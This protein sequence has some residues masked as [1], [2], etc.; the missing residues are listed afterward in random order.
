[1]TSSEW[2]KHAGWWQKGFTDHRIRDAADYG[3]YVE[4]I[5]NNP[6]NKILCVK[7]QEYLYSSV[8]IADKVSSHASFS[9]APTNRFRPA[10][11]VDRPVPPPIATSFR[12][13]FPSELCKY[14]L[15][16]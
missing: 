9:R 8:T 13:Q 2:E 12:L 14:L 4:Y 6:V 7:P 11:R 10:S 15:P 3:K 5:R 1:M 16:E